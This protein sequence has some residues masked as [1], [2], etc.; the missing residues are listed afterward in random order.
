[1]HLGFKKKIRPKETFSLKTRMV[2][3]SEQM[4]YNM[5]QLTEAMMASDNLFYN[6]IN[7]KYL[8]KSPYECLL[9]SRGDGRNNNIY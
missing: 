2:T 1:M 6:M 4:K 8:D 3:G 7:K 9:Q 5:S